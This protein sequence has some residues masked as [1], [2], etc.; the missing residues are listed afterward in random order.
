[1]NLEIEKIRNIAIYLAEKIP[2]LYI[3][4]FLKLFY[5]LDFIAV[6][7]VGNP[8]TNDTYFALP[9][10]PIP[11]FI[12][13]Q[14]SML[15]DAQRVAEAALMKDPTTEVALYNGA[16]IFEN[17]IKLEKDDGIIVK[18]IK[19]FDPTKLSGYEKKLLDDIIETFRDMSVKDIVIKTHTE[20]PYAQTA[21]NNIID[22]R[23]A[24]QM[25]IKDILPK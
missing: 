21:S 10:G 6:Q 12:K 16:G 13:D 24:F 3:T 18:P 14:I 2:N 1:M 23:M 25:N 4:K 8:V 11:S 7:E 20:P 15:D 9:Y 22:Y 17:Y 5:Y 19:E